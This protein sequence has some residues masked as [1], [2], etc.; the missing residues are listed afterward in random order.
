[1]LR[2][3]KHYNLIVIIVASVLCMGNAQK[4][5]SLGRV[6]LRFHRTKEEILQRR[7]HKKM[8]A[9]S[10]SFAP[11]FDVLHL[12]ILVQRCDEILLRHF[13]NPSNDLE[14]QGAMTR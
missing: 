5:N 2:Y 3:I 14:T 8:F 1:M 7:S 12:F 13:S 11:F 6:S 9:L 10:L 4:I